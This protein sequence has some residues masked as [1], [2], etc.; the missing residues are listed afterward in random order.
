[1][2]CVSENHSIHLLFS[3]MNHHSRHHI[4]FFP[5]Q[6]RLIMWKCRITQMQSSMHSYLLIQY[7]SPVD[8]QNCEEAPQSLWVSNGHYCLPY[9]TNSSHKW[10]HFLPTKSL[11]YLHKR[12]KKI[13]YK[14]YASLGSQYHDDWYHT[15]SMGQDIRSHVCPGLTGIPISAP[16]RLIHYWLIP[17]PYVGQWVDLSMQP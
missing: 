4:L 3:I 13:L 8:A 15:D 2:Q 9:V 11:K 12:F 16:E 17:H 14:S 5:K 1:M 7:C 6:Y 10:W